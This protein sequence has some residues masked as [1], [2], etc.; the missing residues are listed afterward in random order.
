MPRARSEL[1]K[2]VNRNGHFS[3]TWYDGKRSQRLSLGTQDPRE[4]KARYAALLSEGGRVLAP[5]SGLTVAL[6]LDDYYKEHARVKC[7]DYV[8]QEN[9]IRHLKAFFGDL[10]LSEID[11]PASRA[12]TQARQKGEIGGGSR[13][14]KNNPA[15]ALSTVRRELNVLKAATT[16]AHRW[17]RITAD[18]LPSIEL[19]TV[20][21]DAGE[22]PWFSKEDTLL[23]FTNAKGPLWCWVRL[24]YWTGAR[25]AS[26]ETLTVSQVNFVTG[27]IRLS[28]PGEKLTKK[29]KP[30]IPIYPQ[31]RGLL[32]ALA[33]DAKAAGRET[34]FAPNVDFYREF[35]RLCEGMALP[36]HHPHALRHSRVTH[37]LMDGDSIYKVARSVGD[38]VAT[39]ERTYGHFSVEFLAE[40]GGA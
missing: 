21:Q 5:A 16:H 34:L 4:A 30:T 26:L 32:A 20:D 15:G 13:R 2:L 27:T 39:I 36:H 23:L 6:A 18:K 38:T 22:A 33:A 3:V 8:R 31:I 24:A 14:G 19:P 9:A 29:R 1:P 28:R 11:I 10:L 7:A 35:R 12:Y 40:K 37:R 25:R 17:K